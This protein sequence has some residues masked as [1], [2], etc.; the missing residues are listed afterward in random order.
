MKQLVLIV[1]ISISLLCTATFAESADKALEIG[2]VGLGG[3]VG[4]QTSSIDGL[5]SNLNTFAIAPNALVYLYQGFAIG[6]EMAFLR[7]SYEDYAEASH[8]YL[9]KLQFAF[10][11]ESNVKPFIHF[12]FGFIRYSESEDDYLY[13][14]EHSENGWTMKAGF[15]LYTFFNDHF[16]LKASVDYL[17]DVLMISQGNSPSTNTFMLTVGFEGFVF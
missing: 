14:G 12:G 1:I 15:G 11:V 2:S 7:V 9:G 8:R 5:D 4:F 6:V 10:P 3:N 17:R 13:G 16:A